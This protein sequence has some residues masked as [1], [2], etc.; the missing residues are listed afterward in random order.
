MS[1][2]ENELSAQAALQENYRR[3]LKGVESVMDYGIFMLDPTG[4]VTTWNE[5]ARRIKGY[6]A[7][8]ILGKHFSLFYP[9][10]A[11]N[12]RHPEYELEVAKEQGRFEEEG[13]RLRKDGT[14]FWANVVIT[15]VYEN[16]ELLGFIKVTR[17]LTERKKAEETL[18]QSEERFR[19]LVEG[20]KDYAIFML[21]PNGFISTW[22]EGARS[23]KGYLASEIIGKHFSIFYPPEAIA[24][25]H[26]EHELKVAI[27]QG[28][29]EEE[30]WRVRKNGDLFWANV[31]ITAL[32]NKE[33]KL[34]GFAKVTRDLTERK[35]VMDALEAAKNKAEAINKELETF[36][37]SISHDLRAP[38]R[39]ITAFTEIVI[40]DKSDQLDEEAKSH[41][42]RVSRNAHQMADLI[43]A[44]LNLS[45][46]SRAEL[47]RESINVSEIV[48]GILVTLQE[49]EPAH[50]VE[51]IVEDSVYCEA[52]PILLR[53]L[54][55]NLLGNAWKFS[56]T[57]E[58]PRIEFGI[59][60][61]D[62]SND[63]D[64]T[65]FYIRDNGA[66][67][68]MKNAAKLFGAFQRLHDVKEY[69]GTGV[70][71]ATVQRIIHRHG[72]TVWAEAVE[73]EGATFYF[74]L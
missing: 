37:Y 71:L 56:A 25:K 59:Q 42:E 38:L 74:T 13:W 17:D 48:R 45:R 33:R 29:F 24:R 72:G 69:P 16:G 53:A 50:R 6:T 30:G 49:Q 60:K 18:R 8:E 5:G 64:K 15:A 52:D 58:A 26:P 54:L 34:I 23:F 43:G 51:S 9:E 19:L 46:L 67:F 68:N 11:K 35:Q 27:E 7:E 62:A 28:C 2:A 14:L 36:A 40:Q 1:C 63:D 4:C 73:N 12:A 32:F 61:R 21:D 66:G 44:L 31:V 20:V 65:V 22:N 57:K 70:G 55:E 39:T 41:L 3:F 10:E 47:T